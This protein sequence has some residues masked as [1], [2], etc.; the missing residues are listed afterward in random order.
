MTAPPGRSLTFP[1][2]PPTLLLLPVGEAGA[3]AAFAALVVLES[4]A[5]AVVLE[6]PVAADDGC[7]PARVARVSTG[8][9]GAIDS[10]RCRRPG[11]ARH[12]RVH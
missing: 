5:A 8:S 11:S 9:A 6:A 2:L 1:R 12:N 4:V 7:V 3:V 10:H